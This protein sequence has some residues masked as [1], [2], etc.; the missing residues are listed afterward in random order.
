M[1]IKKEEDNDPL[2]ANEV[3][4]GASTPQRPSHRP[5]SHPSPFSQ[6]CMSSLSPLPPTNLI[7]SPYP[8]NHQDLTP[9]NLWPLN[10]P[11]QT[12]T[13]PPKPSTHRYIQ[14]LDFK[15]FPT[16]LKFHASSLTVQV[17][18]SQESP[19]SPQDI[20]KTRPRKKSRPRYDA[21]KQ[22][23]CNCSKSRCLKLYCDCFSSNQYCKDC[24]CK[25]CL[26]RVEC[27]AVRKEAANLVLDRNP[28]AFKPKINSIVVNSELKGKHNRGCNCKKSACLKKYCECYQSG[29]KCSD[30]CKCEGCENKEEDRPVKRKKEKINK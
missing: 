12:E 26:N 27:E 28:S 14:K 25:D 17:R 13:H 1:E 9:R 18:I 30:T 6:F 16:T 11:L 7:Y 2:I 24:A 20:P 8:A 4:I 23:T 10:S 19:S 15:S 3:F 22:V 21:P 5:I 29:I